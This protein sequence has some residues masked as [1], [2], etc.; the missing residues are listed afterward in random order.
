M[1]V[2]P[3]RCAWCAKY[4]FPCTDATHGNPLSRYVPIIERM[5][6]LTVMQLSA[7]PVVPGLREPVDAPA[8]Q[9]YDTRPKTAPAVRTISPL[10]IALVVASVVFGLILVTYAIF[11]P[12]PGPATPSCISTIPSCVHT[13][14]PPPPDGVRV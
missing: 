10:A 11:R 5:D 7:I 1:T 14:P 2:V 4:D 3:D 12:L 13:I 6:N 9:V 8:G